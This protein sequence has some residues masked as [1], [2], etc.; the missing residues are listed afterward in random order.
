MPPC[1]GQDELF[2][3][4]KT[5][6]YGMVLRDLDVLAAADPQFWKACR[7]IWSEDCS[8]CPTST[9]APKPKK[10]SANRG[11]KCGEEIRKQRAGMRELSACE[12]A[13]VFDGEP[14]GLSEDED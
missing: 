7:R 2:A 3:A 9:P 5:E 6:A 11:D 13:D 1:S 10:K 12:V 14:E 8:T 4:E